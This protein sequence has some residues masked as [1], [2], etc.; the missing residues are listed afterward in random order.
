MGKATVSR[1]AR[2]GNQPVLLTLGACTAGVVVLKNSGDDGVLS[3]AQATHQQPAR[4]P[5][6]CGGNLRCNGHSSQ[7]KPTWAGTGT[8][9]AIPAV[10]AA[11]GARAH[12]RRSAAS[13]RGDKV[14]RFGG[15]VENKK[16]LGDWASLAP[17]VSDTQD[18]ASAAREL[19]TVDLGDGMTVIRGVYPKGIER[20]GEEY[21]LN[22]GSTDNAYIL[23]ADGDSPWVLIGVHDNFFTD[24]FLEK[25]LGKEVTEKLGHVILQYF[26]GKQMDTIEALI[27]AHDAAGRPPLTFHAAAPIIVAMKKKLPEEVLEKCILDEIDENTSDF[28]FEEGRTL[29]FVLTPT[30]KTPEGLVVFDPKT[31]TVF[32]GKFFSAHKTVTENCEAFDSPGTDGWEQ[33]S[34]DWFH[35]FDCYFFTENAQS[36]IRRLFMLAEALHGPDVSQLA[37]MHGPVVLHQ[38]WKLMA[39]YEAWT[40]QKLRKEDNRDATVLVMYASAYGHTKTLAVSIA[41]GLN[42]AGVNVNMLDLEHCNANQV[43]E[44]LEECQGFFVGSPTLGGEMPT[45]V[46]EALGVVLSA[47]SSEGTAKVPCGVFGSYGWSGEAVDEL[48]F[49]LKDGG[50]PFACDPIRV[51]FRPTNEQLE[52][53]KEAGIRMSQ[54][55]QSM[56]A[57]KQ[58]KRARE[59]DL[60]VSSSASEAFGKMRSSRCMLATLDPEGKDIVTP[61]SWVNQASFDP[62]GITVAVPKKDLDPFLSLG[63]DEQLEILFKRYDVDGGGTL[64]R[65]EITDMLKELFGVRDEQQAKLMEGKIDEALNILDENNDGSVDLEEIKEAS[66]S[67]P[68]AEALENQRKLLALEATIG[69]KKSGEEND[70]L[71]FA[72]NMMPSDISDHDM[73]VLEKHKKAK[74]TN[75]CFVHQ[76]ATAFIECAVTQAL[77]AG[78]HTML[79][80]KVLNGKVLQDNELTGLVSVIQKQGDSE[81]SEEKSPEVAMA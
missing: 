7:T 69:G 36:A 8:V 12:R 4:G 28:E 67:G 13:T 9:V 16:F 61:V 56:F 51:R 58:A 49:R 18:A 79:Y 66:Q 29:K 46:K 75:G 33:F 14:K 6:P 81:A 48:H 77:D 54:K 2:K 43:T 63:T 31:G 23:K 72:L 41:E 65:E 35:L 34:D 76:G 22:S 11:L 44:A 25:G 24:E 5:N 17:S 27:N 20:Y 70:G 74:P 40:E 71:K 80:A 21:S 57:E 37:P 39:K 68:L 15:S 73:N 10:A 50:F 32:S 78:D 60:E 45:Q 52:L 38:C 47:A 55:L 53:C 64:D 59:I 62:P 30:P 26:D 42:T 1:A 19:V 3:F